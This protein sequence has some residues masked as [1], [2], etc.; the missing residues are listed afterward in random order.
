MRAGLFLEGLA[1]S[2]EVRVLVAPVFGPA[3]APGPLVTRCAASCEV[4][5][6]Q[7][8]SL[9]DL[10]ARLR[11]VRGRMRVQSLH[12]LPAPARR[13]GPQAVAAVSDA[14]AGCAAVHVMR[15]Y[16]APLLDGVIDSPPRPPVSL[17]LDELDELEADSEPDAGAYARLAEYY[18]PRV[19]QVFLA[20]PQD[21]AVIS[22][23]HPDLRVHHIANAVSMPPP[24]SL[25][26]PAADAADLVFV[27][28]LSYPPNVEGAAWLVEQVLP[29]L[30]AVK[31]D[32]VGSRPSAEVLRLGSC[33]GV[34]V[35]PDVPDVAPCYARARVAVVPL[36]RGGGTRIKVIEALAHA[37]PV[38]STPVG[39][40]GLGLTDGLAP[41]VL[42]GQEPPEFA[43]ACRRL[44]EDPRLARRLG[45]DGRRQVARAFSRERMVARIDAILT[46]S[47]GS[48]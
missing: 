42:L 4:L 6:L 48:G 28:N 8:A 34:T 47:G 19:D 25:G 33:G 31:V 14:A 26:P 39:A 43:R 15:L 41:P 37:R 38:V 20:A 3:A 40:R 30:G 17:D 9:P 32:L 44:L 21:T 10:G 7:D 35:H 11:T 12:P 27:G 29:Q 23:R 16:L 22:R 36:L 18:L 13:I 1:R 24:H 46:T 2:H 5:E 45:E